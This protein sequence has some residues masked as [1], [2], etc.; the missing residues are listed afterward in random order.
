M[1][2]WLSVSHSSNLTDI[3]H[4]ATSHAASTT[5][6]LA[7]PEPRLDP[8]K[9]KKQTL[10]KCTGQNFRH[11]WCYVQYAV[12]RRL[13]DRVTVHDSD[14]L[15]SLSHSTITMTQQGHCVLSCHTRQ[16]YVSTISIMSGG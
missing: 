10:E 9:K 7:S 8:I 4:T 16:L 2:T 12:A 5:S 15:L 3:P 14:R 13:V 1:Y 11:H 6:I